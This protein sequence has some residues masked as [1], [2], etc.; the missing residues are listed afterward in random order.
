MSEKYPCVDQLSF[1]NLVYRS[2]DKRLEAF[3]LAIE[4]KK[5]NLKWRFPNGPYRADLNETVKEWQALIREM[6]SAVEQWQ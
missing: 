1:A 2:Y 3:E 6:K 4:E 5:S